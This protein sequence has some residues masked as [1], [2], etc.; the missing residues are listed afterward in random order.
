MKV[1]LGEHSISKQEGFE[2][3]FNVSLVVKHYLYRHW[4]FDNDIMLLKVRDNYWT[5]DGECSETVIDEIPIL[6][7]STYLHMTL[8]VGSL[9]NVHSV[10]HND[11]L[12]LN[13]HIGDFPFICHSSAL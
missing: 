13:E 7:L 9:M 8:S 5:Q 11:S 4:T 10:P 1:V 2:Q 3:M 6:Y 12:V